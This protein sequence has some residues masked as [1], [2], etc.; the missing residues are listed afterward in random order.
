MLRG[1]RR[2]DYDP[3]FRTTDKRHKRKYKCGQLLCGP[4]LS[5]VVYMYTYVYMCICISTDVNVYVHILYASTTLGQ[6][7]GKLPNKAQQGLHYKGLLGP[8]G[9]Y[10]AHIGSL[11]TRSPIWLH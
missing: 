7:G 5:V 2:E 11:P 1:R 6:G 10:L 4:C 9:V 3:G 8:I